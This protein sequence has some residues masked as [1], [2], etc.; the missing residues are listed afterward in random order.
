M[1]DGPG[2][3]SE[4]AE[5]QPSSLERTVEKVRVLEEA[6][7]HTIK[8]IAEGHGAK[9]DSLRAR[10]DTVIEPLQQIKDLI[11]RVADEHEFRITALEN[12]TGLNKKTTA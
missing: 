5:T 10:L 2:E 12:Q 7:A 9:L 1:T 4:P 3:R 8:L 11:E 6:N